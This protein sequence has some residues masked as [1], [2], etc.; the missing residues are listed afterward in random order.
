[1]TAIPTVH[2]NGTSRDALL[3]TNKAARH[4]VRKAMDAIRAAAPNARD[5]YVQGP[6]A[7]TAASD[8]HSARIAALQVVYVELTQIV[9]GIFEQ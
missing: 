9:E 2:G 1:M 7:F 3:E 6:C 8:E 4:A 5:F